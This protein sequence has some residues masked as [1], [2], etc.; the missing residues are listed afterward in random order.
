MY[1]AR[2]AR[3]NRF[4][5]LK[6][7]APALTAQLPLAAHLLDEA[8]I[9]ASVRHPNV[10]GVYGAAVHQG[11][12]GFWMEYVAG[13]TLED[14][15]TADGPLGAEEAAAVGRQV[16]RALAAVHNAGLIHRDVKARNIMRERGGRIVLMDFGA[17]ISIDRAADTGRTR[18]GT[19]MYLA[20]E[21]LAGAPATVQ[22]D[23]YAVGVL[24]VPPGQRPV[25][26]HRGLTRRPE[27]AA[28]V[29]AA[30]T[31]AAVAR[32]FPSRSSPSSNAR[33][34]LVDRRFQIGRRDGRGARARNRAPAR[35]RRSAVASPGRVDGRGRLAVSVAV[36]VLTVALAARTRPEVRRHPRRTTRSP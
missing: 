13:D 2:D 5:A 28:R 10:V 20:P 33:S 11:R 27:A 25:P 26:V 3:L 24:H 18:V 6:L 30:R 32:I 12:A 1:L 16:C 8:R 22:S 21:T 14:R 4:V 36:G 34:R 19:P 29:G 23:V 7:L 17:G 35:A 9:L 31:P 15:L